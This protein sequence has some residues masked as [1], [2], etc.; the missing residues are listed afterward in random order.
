MRAQTASAVAP[1][2]RDTA[3]ASSISLPTESKTFF[4][5][6]GALLT[7]MMLGFVGWYV[8][9]AREVGPPTRTP[10]TH[11]AETRAQTGAHQGHEAHTGSDTAMADRAHGEPGIQPRSQPSSQ[12]PKTPAQVVTSFYGALSKGDGHA[13][14]ALVVP[15]KQGKEAFNASRMSRFYGAMQQP[16]RVHLLRQIDAQRL[17]VRYSYRVDKTTCK[18]TAIVTTE[19]VD[20]HVMIRS[21]QANC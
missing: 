4:L 21:I 6:L 1:D 17:E 10:P 5:R 19:Q 15:S 9:F 16:I 11:E 14:A 2:G 20:D 3:P 12:L 7:A 13:A 18:G 8:Y